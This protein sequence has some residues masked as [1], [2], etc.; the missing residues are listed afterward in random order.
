MTQD[1]SQK[2]GFPTLIAPVANKLQTA[3]NECLE[4]KASLREKLLKS[5][6]LLF[7]EF[8]VRSPIQFAQFVRQFSDRPLQS[9]VGGASPRRSL[10]SGVYTSTEYAPQVTVSLH[11]EMSYTYRWP[12]LVF[13]ACV[14]APKENGETPI[15]DS[16]ALLR[17]I[18]PD[19][20]DE[21]SKKQVQYLRRLPSFTN[22]GYS[23][24]EAFETDSRQVVEEYCERGK[25]SFEWRT[26]GALL[27]TETRPATTTHPVTGEEVW[28][29]QADSFH[30][31][32]NPTSRLDACFGDGSQISERSIIRIRKAMA[33]QTV[34][35]KWQRGDILVLDNLLTAHGRRPFL[36]P[37]EILVAMA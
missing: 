28:F 18:G 16:R 5:G 2:P 20:V 8:P 30:S 36:G 37:R 32:G 25:I 24:Q 31:A 35:F 12:D 26:D 13:F 29:N 10:V 3:L 19:I 23:W 9:Y 33:D 15:A 14:V 34:L 7:R 27:L 22:D 6:A 11:N 4:R 1:I 21:F 17:E